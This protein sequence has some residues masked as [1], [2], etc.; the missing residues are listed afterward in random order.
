MKNYLSMS[1][2]AAG[3]PVKKIGK[4]KI[5]VSIPASAAQGNLYLKQG[6]ISGDNIKQR[7]LDIRKGI[8]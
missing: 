6:Y 4:T 5:C 1:E 2:W 7:F 3:F 8:F